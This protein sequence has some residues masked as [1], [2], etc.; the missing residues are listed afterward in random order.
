MFYA[1][2]F[3]LHF[4]SSSAMGSSAG[5]AFDGIMEWSGDIL[6][7]GY[8]DQAKAYVIGGSNME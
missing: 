6:A 1:S 2:V 5:R 7:L 8:P 3:L 4:G